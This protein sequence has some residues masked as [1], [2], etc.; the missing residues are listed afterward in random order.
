MGSNDRSN[1]LLQ[2]FLTESGASPLNL[3]STAGKNYRH[4]E[5]D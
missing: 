2:N 4:I 5:D 1:R 3:N